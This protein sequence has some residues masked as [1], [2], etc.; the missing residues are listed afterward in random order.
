MM[1]SRQQYGR[2]CGS[3]NNLNH[4]KTTMSMNVLHCE[5][6]AGVLKELLMLR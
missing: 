5:T 3:G 6:V 2:R 4:L 1:N